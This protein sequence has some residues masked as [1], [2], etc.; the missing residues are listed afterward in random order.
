MTPETAAPAPHA[1]RWRGWLWLSLLANALLAWWLWRAQPP[2]PPPATPVGESVLLRTPGGRLEISEIQQTESF[3]VS[4]DH[5]VLGGP[6]GS[7]FSRI[8]VPAHYRYH[9]ELAPEW[10]VRVLPDGGV[11]VIAPRV[12]PSLPVAIDTAQ[13]QTES[14]GLWSLFTG[15]AQV[16]AL[17]RSITAQ[18]ARK[19][20]TAPM[21]ERQREAA[22][23]T[24]SEFVTKWLMTQSEW[25]P[26]AG[27]PVQVLFADEPIE[28]LD[29][30]C[31]SQPDCVAQ[32]LNTTGL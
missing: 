31:G 22:R 2:A 8:R 3:E 1:R 6:V 19:A 30:A 29:A 32:W 7:T 4:R 15:P 14:R 9:V 28:A 23:K 17:E 13:L 25:R 10:R 20:V 11:R 12:Q 26:H 16:K 18:L 27:Q 5:D 21:L 24:V